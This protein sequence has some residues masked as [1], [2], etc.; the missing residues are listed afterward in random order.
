MVE[1][2]NISVKLYEASYKQTHNC[3]V[4]YLSTGEIEMFILKSLHDIDL[5]GNKESDYFVDL[6][7]I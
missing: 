5:I 3:V 2:Q 4:T 6:N 7:S 1:K